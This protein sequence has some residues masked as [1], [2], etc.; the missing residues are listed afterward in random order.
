MPDGGVSNDVA[1]EQNRDPD[2][3]AGLLVFDKT[4]LFHREVIL[5]SVGDLSMPFP[6]RVSQIVYATLFLLLW[7][8][9][10]LTLF[11]MHMT[12]WFL[13]FAFGPPVALA[14]LAGRPIWGGKKL[15]GFVKSN[16]AFAV[17]PK[18]W[19]DMYATHTEHGAWRTDTAVWVS[20]RAELRMLEEMDDVR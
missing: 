5:Y 20:R 19:T 8:G 16:V 13:L 4:G 11:G 3:V 1:G 17:S 14:Y 15:P 7:S 12:W 18:C 2:N 10:I 6:M 9:P